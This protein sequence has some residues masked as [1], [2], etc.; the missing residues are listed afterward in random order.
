MVRVCPTAL[1]TGPILRTFYATPSMRHLPPCGDQTVTPVPQAVSRC[2]SPSLPRRLFPISHNHTM[3]S[4]Y[5]SAADE[6]TSRLIYRHNNDRCRA[7]RRGSAGTTTITNRGPA[8]ALSCHSNNSYGGRGHPTA[9]WRPVRPPHGGSSAGHSGHTA[10][11]AD[12]A[13]RPRSLAAYR[14]RHNRRGTQHTHR[15]MTLK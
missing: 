6:G 5:Y 2:G 15:S 14:S 3:K 7:A 4:V 11:D 1:G 10:A 12:S 9:E 13:A 8:Y